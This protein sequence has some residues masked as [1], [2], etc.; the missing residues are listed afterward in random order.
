MLHLKCD[1]QNQNT[2]KLKG[3]PTDLKEAGGVQNGCVAIE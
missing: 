3:E 2:R 1:L